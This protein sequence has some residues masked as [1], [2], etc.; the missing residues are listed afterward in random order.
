MFAMGRGIPSSEVEVQLMHHAGRAPQ[1]SLEM[2][3][4]EPVVLERP[5]SSLYSGPVTLA[6]PWCGDEVEYQVLSVAAARLQ[7]ALWRV[8]AVAGLAA[9]AW[10]TVLLIQTGGSSSAGASLVFAGLVTVFLFGSLWSADYGVNGPGAWWTS[11]PH[12]LRLQPP[13]AEDELGTLTCERCGH[14][15]PLSNGGYAAAKARMARHN[16]H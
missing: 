16:C 5:P 9:M 7:W 1:L 3:R 6:C 12:S 15:E 10:G 11:R 14:R 4:I 8:L 13:E 2:Y